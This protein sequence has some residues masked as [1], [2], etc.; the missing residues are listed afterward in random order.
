MRKIN[1]KIQ[2]NNL[3]EIETDQLIWEIENSKDFFVYE[4]NDSQE[5]AEILVKIIMNSDNSFN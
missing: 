5:N 2:I 1:N 3:E 4:L